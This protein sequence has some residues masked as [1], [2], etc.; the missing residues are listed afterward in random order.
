MKFWNIVQC[1]RFRT[2][3]TGFGIHSLEF[4]EIGES[5]KSWG[6]GFRIEISV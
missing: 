2:L 1:S 6:S 3:G 4:R 5:F